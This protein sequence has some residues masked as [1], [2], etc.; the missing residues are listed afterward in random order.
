MININIA[1]NVIKSEV[2]HYLTKRA[3]N[4]HESEQ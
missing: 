1:L 3:K 4:E 2:V